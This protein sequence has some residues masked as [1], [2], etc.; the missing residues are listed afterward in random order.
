MAQNRFTGFAK[1]LLGIA[2]QPGAILIG[3]LLIGGFLAYLAE[4]GEE[5]ALL[6]KIA[7]VAA[8]AVLS[9]GVFS[10]ILS[11]FRFSGIF[12]EEVSEA[13]AEGLP[14]VLHGVLD[15]RECNPKREDL[16]EIWREATKKLLPCVDDTERKQIA[17]HLGRALGV[18]SD[19][20]AAEAVYEEMDLRYEISAI[21]KD[22]YQVESEMVAV[23][24]PSDPM[25][26][27]L[28][29]W[30]W[31][32]CVHEGQEFSAQITIDDDVY[33]P[34]A[35]EEEKG[36]KLV[37]SMSK[38]LPPRDSYRVKIEQVYTSAWD[39]EP[40]IRANFSRI[41]RGLRLRIKCNRGVNA[42]IYG[43]GLGSTLGSGVSL[44]KPAA[45][46]SQ[47]KPVLPGQG[48]FLHLHAENVESE[49]T[50]EDRIRKQV[51]AQIRQEFLN[52]LSLGGEDGPPPEPS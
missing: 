29:S 19:T 22:L 32:E 23:L 14:G 47:G 33:K 49:P 28:F 20:H 18:G 30:G 3:S 35:Q 12:Q 17:D 10:A 13:L 40:W 52:K 24:R 25:T 5:A 4:T 48:F 41:I 37:A 21:G 11:T 42:R 6:T 44:L 36:G 43:F 26:E 50:D 1:K 39:S 9:G 2:T 46:S 51:R 7:V 15:E 38:G 45:W 34:E 8:P 27:T 31:Y 16:E